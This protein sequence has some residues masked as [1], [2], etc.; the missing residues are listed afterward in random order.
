MVEGDKREEDE[1]GEYATAQEGRGSERCSAVSC[2]IQPNRVL[3]PS[4]HP[5]PLPNRGVMQCPWLRSM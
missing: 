1:Q 5:S 3:L 2:G 4:S